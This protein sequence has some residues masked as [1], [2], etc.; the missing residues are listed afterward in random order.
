MDGF[1]LTWAGECS[2]WECD[3]LGHLNM[4]NYVKKFG[5]ARKGLMI[6]LGL[7]EAF[8]PGTSSSIRVRDFHIK[9]Q[10]EARPGNPLLSAPY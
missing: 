6:R 5:E 2:S 7:I 9:Y 1:V 4:R 10:G 8:K 3:D